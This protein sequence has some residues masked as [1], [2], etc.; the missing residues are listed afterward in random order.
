VPLEPGSKFDRYTIEALLGEGGMGQ[1]YKA[2]DARLERR[3]ALKIL[4]PRVAADPEKS[5]ADHWIL[6]EAR[7]AAALD[8]P[9]AVSIFELGE[10]DGVPFMAMEFISGRSLR[11]FVGRHSVP[12]DQ[13]ARWL[14]DIARALDAAHQAGI[15]HLDIKPENVM[16]RADGVVKVLDFGIARRT[17]ILETDG[18][19]GATGAEGKLMTLT[20]RGVLVGTP[21]Y[22]A[23]EQVVRKRALDG[24]ADQFAWGVVAYEIFAGKTPWSA[25]GSLYDVLSAIVEQAPPSLY[26]ACRGDLPEAM[27]AAVM[28]ALLKS[29]DDRFPTMAEAAEALLAPLGMRMATPSWTGVEA[30]KIRVSSPDLET[31][32]RIETET[33]GGLETKS[34]AGAETRPVEEG[35]T[36]PVSSAEIEAQVKRLARSE[37]GEVDAPAPAPAPAP[38]SSANEAAPGP[39]VAPAT[40]VAPAPAA[41]EPPRRPVAP[42]APPRRAPRLRMALLAAAAIF[43]LS[44]AAFRITRPPPPDPTPSATVS[45]P[46]PPPAPTAIT[47][48]PDP[49]HCSE[50]ALVEYRAGIRALRDGAWE[51]AHQNFE[52]AAAADPQCAGAHLRLSITGHYH[53]SISRTRE[54]Y[55]R[56]RQLRDSLGDRDRKLLEALE[57]LLFRDPVDEHEYQERLRRTAEAYPADAELTCMAAD[58]DDDLSHRIQTLRRAIEL[59]PHYSDAWQVLADTLALQGKPDE[60]LAALDSCLTAAP[61]SVDCLAERSA[62]LQRLGRCSEMESTARQWIARDPRSAMAYSTLA[63]ALSSMGSREAAEEALHRR[64]ALLPEADRAEKRLHDQ[65]LLAA[66]GGDFDGAA[67]RARELSEIAEA[68]PNF[69]RHARP[70]RLLAD[71]LVETDRAAAAGTLA[72]DFLKRK[73]AWSANLTP[74]GSEVRVSYVEP[75]L[76][77]V[78]RR[79]G[80]LSPR[81]WEAAHGAWVE[82]TRKAGTFTEEALWAMGSAMPAETPAE[83]A[84]AIRAM[85]A[86]LQRSGGRLRAPMELS[87][88]FAGKALLLAGQVDDALPFLRVAGASCFAFDDPFVHTEAQLWLGQALEQK[89]DF[90]GACAA[91]RVVVARWGAAS[92]R[93]ST[94]ASARRRLD[95]LAGAKA[96]AASCR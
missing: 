14:G 4:R 76:L 86:S 79:A 38:V 55:G 51:Q 54:V 78:M 75:M 25:E 41:P 3:V 23:P 52:H 89:G 92:P 88:A 10:H 56:A 22:M 30:P 50:A 72:A 62:H 44:A 71:L 48:L 63:S 66:L 42:A 34:L 77:R 16:V 64:W 40:K 9:N 85:P 15:I 17:S 60:A 45:A 21:P 87:G 67:K 82:S 59:D 53:Y 11:A 28:R 73:S 36:R 6:R 35:D 96:S 83:A 43:G 47:D 8:H 5:R 18:P 7:A 20:G 91:Y 80:R 24:R 90:A 12:L 49:Q 74:G 57:P 27:A 39:E 69:E 58:Y 26:K 84:A 19:E 81:E 65:A 1:V 70:T 93:S 33:L 94:A 68:D 61:N 29:P 13:R 2:F 32:G 31:M 95:A 46:A 37:G